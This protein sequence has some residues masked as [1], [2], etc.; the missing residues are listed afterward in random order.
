MTESCLFVYNKL[1][2]ECWVQRITIV[3]NNCKRAEPEFIHV[4]TGSMG[5]IYER[6]I[7]V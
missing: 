5:F 3:I 4:R 6:E 1:K 7:V 2:F